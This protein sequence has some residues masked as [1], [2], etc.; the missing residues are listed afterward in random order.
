MEW[1]VVTLAFFKEPAGKKAIIVRGPTMTASIFASGHL[2]YYC[3]FSLDWTKYWPGRGP[4]RDFILKPLQKH[5]TKVSQTP[6]QPLL[7]AKLKKEIWLFV[8]S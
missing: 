6:S 7:R 4:D 8:P 1:R 5:L 2:V 3:P